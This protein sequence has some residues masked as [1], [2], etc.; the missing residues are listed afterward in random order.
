MPDVIALAL[1]ADLAFSVRVEEVANRL[2]FRVA[3]VS[4]PEKAVGALRQGRASLFVIDLAAAGERAGEVIRAAKAAPYPVA[5]LA[6]GPG[7]ELAPLESEIDLAVS[8]DEFHRNPGRWLIT[9]LD[10]HR[11]SQTSPERDQ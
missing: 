7:A 4:S 3:T 1:I 9:C 11:E 2:G 6:F 5:V 10:S 8:T